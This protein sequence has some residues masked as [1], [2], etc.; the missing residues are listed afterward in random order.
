MAYS[1]IKAKEQACLKMKKK[2]KNR[3]HRYGINRRRSR[4]EHKHSKYMKCLSVIPKQ[5]LKLNS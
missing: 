4:Q 2:M 1:K 3:S 5:H